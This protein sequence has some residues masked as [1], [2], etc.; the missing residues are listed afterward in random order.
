MECV[1]LFR[2]TGNG[3]VGF[4]S[5]GDEIAVFKDRVEASEFAQS[6]DCPPVLDAYPY[7]IVEL[8]DL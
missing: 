6:T 5:D 2:N 1:I 8:D 3:A 7:Q 4:I